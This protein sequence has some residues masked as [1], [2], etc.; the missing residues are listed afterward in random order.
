[1]PIIIH[2]IF[3]QL[4]TKS[5]TYTTATYVL[6]MH[7]ITK[8]LLQHQ[9]CTS[10]LPIINPKLPLHACMRDINDNFDLLK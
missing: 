5:S 6:H 1:M 2:H 4:N 3:I 10:K 7:I 9:S 8:F